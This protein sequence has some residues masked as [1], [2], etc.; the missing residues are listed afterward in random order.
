MYSYSQHWFVYM[1]RCADGSL[2]VGVTD[3]L[4]RSVR[5]MNRRE[6]PSYADLCAPVTLVYA[7][8]YMNEWDADRRAAQIRRMQKRT[9]ERLIMSENFQPVKNMAYAI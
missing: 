7:E 3:D 1:V 4:K 6:A 2:F 9:K 5:K 8:E